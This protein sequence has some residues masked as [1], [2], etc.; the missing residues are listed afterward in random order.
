MNSTSN[1]IGAMPAYD[2]APWLDMNKHIRNRFRFSLNKYGELK[3]NGHLVAERDRHDIHVALCNEFGNI[4]RGAVEAM[5][6]SFLENE[7]YSK[8]DYKKNKN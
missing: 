6:M 2:T 5:L 8:R 7:H 3:C 4:S 1:R